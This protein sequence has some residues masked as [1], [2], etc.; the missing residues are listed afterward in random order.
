VFSPLAGYRCPTARVAEP[1]RFRQ[2]TFASAQGFFRPLAVGYVHHGTDE[3]NEIAGWAENGMAHHVDISDLAA[4]MNDSVI[5]LE[6]RSF[7]LC[8]LDRFP[9]SG[10][11][12]RMNALKEHFVSRLATVRIKT[13]HPV[14]FFGH[15]PDLARGRHPRPTA[16][17]AEPLRLRQ[18]ALASAQ[19]LFRPLAL[20]YIDHGADEFDEIAGWADNGMAYHVDVSDVAAGMNDSVIQLVPRLLTALLSR[21]FP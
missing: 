8:F 19:G 2:I 12:I 13:Q 16:R 4:G 17:V 10:L 6:I 3:F 9:D 15:V 18:I 7:T 5:Q 20:G 21:L 14:A 1:L 11:I